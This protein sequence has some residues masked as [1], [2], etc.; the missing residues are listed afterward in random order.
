MNFNS[1]TRTLTVIAIVATITLFLGAIGVGEI[2][3]NL[4]HDAPADI[5]KALVPVLASHP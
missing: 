3:V 4:M 5:H 2:M 1:A